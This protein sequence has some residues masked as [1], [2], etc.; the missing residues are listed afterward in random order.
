[1]LYRK[2]SSLEFN[3]KIVTNGIK[4]Q[5]ITK[6]NNKK[7]LLHCLIIFKRDIELSLVFLYHSKQKIVYF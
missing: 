7:T 6:N 1:M 4:L 3:R 2:T 5:P